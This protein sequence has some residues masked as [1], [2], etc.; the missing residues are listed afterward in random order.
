[1]YSFFFVLFFSEKKRHGIL[2]ELSDHFPIQ[3]TVHW[4][5]LHSKF[6]FNAEIQNFTEYFYPFILNFNAEI[7]ITPSIYSSAKDLY[8]KILFVIA[9]AVIVLYGGHKFE[10][11]TLQI[12]IVLMLLNYLGLWTE[13]NLCSKLQGRIGDNLHE[14]S[15]PNF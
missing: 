8:F 6:Y 9:A 1:M 11:V 2:C 3:C 15:D 10:N 7:S 4:K 13:K 12:N 5:W 14:M